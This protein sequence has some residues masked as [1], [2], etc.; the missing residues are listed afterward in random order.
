MRQAVNLVE[1]LIA[2]RKG[3]FYLKAYLHKFSIHPEKPE[4]GKWITANSRFTQPQ[5]GRRID[6][7][8]KFSS[9]VNNLFNFSNRYTF[10]SDPYPLHT[11]PISFSTLILILF[12]ILFFI[13]FSFLSIVFSICCLFLLLSF[14]IIIFSF[15]SIFFL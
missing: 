13:L 2:L 15:Y 1:T 6:G 8:Q 5:F 9:I 7:P 3:M 12:H 14:P 10:E 4:V 11:I